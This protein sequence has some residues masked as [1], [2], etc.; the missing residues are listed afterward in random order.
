M[1][2]IWSTLDRKGNIISIARE[3]DRHGPDGYAF[4]IYAGKNCIWKR[5]T[6]KEAIEYA[7][8]ICV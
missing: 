8:R 1:N 4:Y 6:R 5:N 7:E 2:T 3:P